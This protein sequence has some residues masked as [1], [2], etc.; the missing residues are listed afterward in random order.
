LAIHHGRLAALIGVK[1]KDTLVVAGANEGNSS[2]SRII[3]S[4]TSFGMAIFL[5][6]TFVDLAINCKRSHTSFRSMG[7]GQDGG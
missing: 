4:R 2:A 5:L 7:K 6:K 3:V 1:G